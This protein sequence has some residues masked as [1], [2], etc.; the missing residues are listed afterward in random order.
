MTYLTLAA[1]RPSGSADIARR[2]FADAP[3]FARLAVFLG[4]SLGVT[5][6]AAQIDTRLWLGENIWLK[7]IKFQLSLTLYLAT[8][9]VFARW[10]PERTRASLWF[11]TF[12]AIVCLSILA[13][14]AWIAGAAAFGTGS[15]FNVAT[16]FMSAIYSL[17]GLF[18][19]TLTSATLVMGL[20]VWRNPAT[21]LSP[22][23]KLSVV[24]GL[25]LTFVLTVPVAGYMASTEGH[26]V[27]TPVTDARLWPMGW[28]REVGDLRIAHFFAAHALHF[29][30][31]GGVLATLILPP[32]GAYAAVI[33]GTLAFVAF[34][35]FT[36]WQALNGLPLIP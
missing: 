29:L 20:S 4:L 10:M 16:P 21:G 5:L 15:H 7:P 28:S 34:T 14:M 2:A 6:L 26:L 33:A 1:P 31:A 19:V 17:M 13:E 23:L 12:A 22:A 27:G 32:R 8:L 36:F 11:R 9:A 35:G 30:P 24:L 18:A 25:I 3:A